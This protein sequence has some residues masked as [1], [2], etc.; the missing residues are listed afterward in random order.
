MKRVLRISGIVFLILA[1]A[2]III[3]WVPEDRIEMLFAMGSTGIF[4]FA[5]GYVW[6]LM[7]E[8]RETDEKP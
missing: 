8:S 5:M 7:A 4:A 1:I 3:F 6:R 2:A